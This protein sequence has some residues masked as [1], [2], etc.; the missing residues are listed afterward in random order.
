[1]AEVTAAQAADILAI[2][3]MTIHRRVEDGSLPARREGVK[4]IVKIDVEDLRQFAK[5]YS[6]RFNETIAQRSQ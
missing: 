5:T 1:M 6:Y 4:G 3:H 2:S